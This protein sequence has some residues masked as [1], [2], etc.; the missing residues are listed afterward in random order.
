MDYFTG[1]SDKSCWGFFSNYS[2]FPVASEG[3]MEPIFLLLSNNCLELP[4]LENHR[5][6]IPVIE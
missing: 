2:V 3:F 4:C 5:E 1:D 6:I